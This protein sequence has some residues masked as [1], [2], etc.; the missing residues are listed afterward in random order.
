MKLHFLTIVAMLAMLGGCSTVRQT[1]NLDAVG[2]DVA[3]GAYGGYVL[4]GKP[5]NPVVEKDLGI[6]A[7]DLNGVDIWIQ[8]NPGL[9]DTPGYNYAGVQ[10]L[11]IALQIATADVAGLNLIPIIPLA[12]Q[13]NAHKDKHAAGK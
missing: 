7:T 10:P 1:Y 9:A 3:A 13:T 8:A 5:A 12:L 4:S 11:N 6:V 2:Y